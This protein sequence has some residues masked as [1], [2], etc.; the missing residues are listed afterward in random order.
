MREHQISIEIAKEHQ[1]SQENETISSS[2]FLVADT[3][4]QTFRL[5]GRALNLY[6]V[7]ESCSNLASFLC[8]KQSL[9]KHHVRL[10]LLSDKSLSENI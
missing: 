4:L 9:T 7:V 1:L 8:L 6:T 2:H 3:K 10:H 5:N